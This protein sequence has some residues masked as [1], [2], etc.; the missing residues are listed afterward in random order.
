[1][2]SSSKTSRGGWFIVGQ[3]SLF[4]LIAF[5]PSTTD[6]LPPWSP[7]WWNIGSVAGGVLFAAGGLLALVATLQHGKFFTPFVRP[8]EGSVLLDRGAY[9]LVRHPIYSGLLFMGFGWG[10]WVHGWLTLGYTVLLLILL[11]MKARREEKWLEKQFPGYPAYKRR[12][13]RFFPYLY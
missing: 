12:V 9:R 11:D 2:T 5:G 13:R 3:F 4:A 10:L 6:A 7:L 1:M 8:R